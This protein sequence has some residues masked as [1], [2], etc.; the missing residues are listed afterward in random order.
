MPHIDIR[1]ATIGDVPA[2][3][4]IIAQMDLD[5]DAHLPLPEA[6]EIF[7]RVSTYGNH[8]VYVATA[9][10]EVVGTFVLLI[11]HHLSHHGARSVIIDDVV[12]RDDW[13][14]KGVGRMMMDYAV[15]RGKAL[16]CYKFMLSSG[17]RRERAHAFYEDLGFQKHGYSFLLTDS[18]RAPSGE[19]QALGGDAAAH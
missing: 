15:R 6:E 12:V 5:G 10:S 1:R 2:I 3:M 19:S 16:G 7:T 18:D 9:D 13:R 11:M 8:E 14:G 17:I 4:P